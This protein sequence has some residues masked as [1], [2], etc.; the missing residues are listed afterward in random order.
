MNRV[1]IIDLMG[2]KALSDEA[3][4]S[5]ADQAGEALK[6]VGFFVIANCGIPP[7]LANQTREICRQ[8]FELPEDQKLK[9]KTPAKGRPQGYLPLGAVALATAYGTARARPIS[10][11]A[12]PF[13]PTTRAYSGGLARLRDFSRSSTPTIKRL[14]R[15]DRR[16][17]GFLRKR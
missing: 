16:C 15:L 7:G 10:R 4:R 11:R 3:L 14:T 5:I 12:I 8:F 9:D 17:C 13:A 2:G 1:P 6:H